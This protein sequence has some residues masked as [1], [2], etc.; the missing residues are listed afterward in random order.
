MSENLAVGRQWIVRGED[1]GHLSRLSDALRGL[2]SKAERGTDLIA[3][4]EACDAIEK[5]IEGQPVDI[6]VG[7]SIGFRR[8]RGKGN[9]E[10]EEGLF[11]DCRI[12]N[13]EVLLTELRTTYWARVGSDHTDDTSASFRPDGSSRTAGFYDWLDLLTEVRECD[14]AR[15]S[16]ERD[17]A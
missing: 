12:N 4:G 6:D 2:A 17:H 14:D 1:I 16:T 8:G 3:L 15:L 11:L 13:N 9:D 7:V 5:I 10:T